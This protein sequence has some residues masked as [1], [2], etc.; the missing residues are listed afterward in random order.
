MWLIDAW[1]EERNK[2]NKPNQKTNKQ[3]NKQRKL[4]TYQEPLEA[5]WCHLVVM[6]YSWLSTM[7]L[8]WP[9]TL[10][11]HF[12]LVY[13]SCWYLDYSLCIC[14]WFHT[15]GNWKKNNFLFVLIKILAHLDTSEISIIFCNQSLSQLPTKLCCLSLHTT[16]TKTV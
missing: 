13:Y 10:S 6:K 11:F 16:C 9:R 7:I 2:Q 1:K 4:S 3:Q 5:F 14:S 12:T 8:R 15:I